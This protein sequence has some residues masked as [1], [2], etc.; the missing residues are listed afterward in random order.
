MYTHGL[1]VQ[2]VNKMKWDFRKKEKIWLDKISISFLKI[3]NYKILIKVFMK[4]VRHICKI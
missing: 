3:N 4:D 2:K 1:R